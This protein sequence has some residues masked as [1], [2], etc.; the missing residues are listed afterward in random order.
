MNELPLWIVDRSVFFQKLPDFDDF[1]FM[2]TVCSRSRGGYPV[3]AVI[4]PCIFVEN[5]KWPPGLEPTT[6]AGPLPLKQNNHRMCAGAHLLAASKDSRMD[7]AVVSGEH[8][9][10]WIAARQRY[11]P[12]PPP[13]SPHTCPPGSGGGPTPAAAPNVRPGIQTLSQEPN[14]L[15][16]TRRTE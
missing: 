6:C 7:S 11:S 12:R 10:E 16:H 3:R 15:G 8:W 2:S 1:F 4:Y 13:A 9:Y 5:T 14:P